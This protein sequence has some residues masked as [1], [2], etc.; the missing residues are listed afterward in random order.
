M[1][2]ADGSHET[3]LTSGTFCDT[4]RTFSPDGRYIAFGGYG[5]GVIVGDLWI[6]TADG[7]Q[8]HSILQSPGTE[9]FP[10]WQPTT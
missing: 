1:I 10:D 4:G 2:D 9:G 7:Q 8:L 3:G 5:E 6:M